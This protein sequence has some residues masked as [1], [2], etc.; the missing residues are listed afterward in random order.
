MIYV[1]TPF[2]GWCHMVADS[3]EEL[4]VF[5]DK[6]GINRQRFQDKPFRPH[7]DLRPRTRRKAVEL[8]AKEVQRRELMLVLK[9]NYG[10]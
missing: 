8:G 3:I 6:L 4:H 2:D 1:D 7:Y 5:A 10:R 9:N